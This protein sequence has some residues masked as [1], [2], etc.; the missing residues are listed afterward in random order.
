MDFTIGTRQTKIP[1]GEYS[2]KAMEIKEGTFIGKRKS[3]QF[4]F[5]IAAG[6]YRGTQLR[7]WVNAHY[8]SFSE[9]TKLFRWYG[10]ACKD[11][12]DIG[13]KKTTD[14]FFDK[15]LKIKVETK[16]SKKTKNEFSNVTDILGVVY[17]L[18]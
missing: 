11:D 16:S 14:V 6:E 5:E 7:G 3:L 9:H 13:E 18:S 8:D 10:V 12:M 15:I 4:T 17:D 2:A 1:P